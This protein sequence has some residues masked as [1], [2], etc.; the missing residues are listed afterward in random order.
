MEWID[1]ASLAGFVCTVDDETPI[2]GWALVLELAAAVDHLRAA[3]SDTLAMVHRDIKPAN[4]V[5][6][7]TRG[8]VLV[9]FGLARP[10]VVAATTPTAGTDW[11]RAPELTEGAVPSRETD[12]WSTVATAHF[13]LTGSAPSSSTRAQLASVAERVGA[14]PGSLVGAFERALD[15]DPAGRP[16]S[17]VTWAGEVASILGASAPVAGGRVMANVGARS[18]TRRQRRRAAVAA[19]LVVLGLLAAVLVYRSAHRTGTAAS[20][21]ASAPPCRVDPAT[22]KATNAQGMSQAVASCTLSVGAVLFCT[23]DLRSSTVGS[24]AGDG[25]SL[26]FCTTLGFSATGVTALG[27]TI[28]CGSGQR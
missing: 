16:A 6:D 27:G 20:A 14:D 15:R 3:S 26:V 28:T 5:A 1:G 4:V 2:A 10:E 7:P 17:M 24:V 9:D 22:P 18:R 21:G 11:Y 19:S 23:R 8:A 25:H 12:R 13:V